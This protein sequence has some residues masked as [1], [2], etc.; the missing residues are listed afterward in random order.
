MH[1]KSLS[2][3]LPF[4]LICAFVCASC[5]GGGGGGNSNP[6]PPPPPPVDPPQFVEVTN[7]SG[8]EFGVGYSEDP[9]DD[10]D[11]TRFAGGAAAGDYD[12]DGDIDLFVVR[13]DSGSN[14]L[15]RNDGNNTFTN[16]S[17]AAG[18]AFTNGGAATY[19]HSGPMFADLDGDADLDLFVGGVQGDPSVLFQNNGDGTFSDVTTGSGID[20][21]GAEHNVSAAFGDYDLD[22]DL[23]MAVAH[24]GT[25]RSNANPGDTEHLWRNDS[26][27]GQII[28]VSQ[29]VESGLS[30]DIVNF[31]DPFS[32]QGDQ[33][34]SFSPAFV[35]LNDDLYPDIIMVSDFGKT[36]IF[37]NN[38]D[39]TFT[40]TTD[41][42]VIRDTNGMGLAIGDYDNDGDLDI[43][44][45]SIYRVGREGING[46]R[47][48]R[49]DGG[50][51]IDD[52]D[53]AGVDDGGW[54]WAA[55]FID[56]ENDGDLDLYHTNGW[57]L[58]TEDDYT[59]DRSRAFVSNGAGVFVDDADD[60]GLVDSEQGRGVVCADFDQDGDV[61]IFLW[62]SEVAT[63]GR[64]FRND[65]ADNNYL[66]VNLRGKAPNTA[67]AGA[68]IEVTIG[69]TTQM[70]EVSL[71]SNFVSQN[72]TEQVFGLGSAM[73]VDSL[74]VE[75][76]D[77][78]T[79]VM[80]TVTA[81]QN[82]IIDHPEL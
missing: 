66:T 41:V 23:D 74:T 65:E 25:V 12:N 24:W 76:P 73:Q 39:G 60:L 29:S 72:P 2:S 34:F 10:I 63:A 58:I 80:G 52:T 61:D 13:G 49:N 6:P 67:A 3:F 56:F 54:G 38:Q 57:Q 15:Y 59:D 50:M 44:V 40:N 48:Y 71:A 32:G 21:M 70:R 26:A 51:F 81:N 28:F 55:C 36:Q 5:S 18:V 19:R 7:G 31:P 78:Q 27:G 9:G 79:T 22:G 1:K 68:R 53:T 64:L 43:F 37:M 14:L 20:L 75:W 17:G 77:G 11:V 8:I 16:V 4:Y 46:N 42:D 45:S 62:S 35:R 33:D 82:L 30:P 47:L 69:G